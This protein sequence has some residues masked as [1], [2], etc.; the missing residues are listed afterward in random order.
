MSRYAVNAFMRLVNMDPVA[1]AA[2]VGEPAAFV[3]SWLAELGRPPLSVEE[4]QALDRRDYAALYRL[5]AHPYLLWS[6]TEAVWV[7]EVS[8]ADLIADYKAAAA[9]VGYPDCRTVPAPDLL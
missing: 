8:R 9:E 7:P 6:F 2:Y 5:G 1:L 3:A 4:R